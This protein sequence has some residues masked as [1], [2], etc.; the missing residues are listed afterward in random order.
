MADKSG[1]QPG[2]PTAAD[3]FAGLAKCGARNRRGEPCRRVGNGRNGRCRLHGGAS[4]GAPRGERN[5]PYKTGFY[6]ADAIAERRR[7]RALIR[8]MKRTLKDDLP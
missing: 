1:S 2:E 5:G 6:T 4:T 8:E 3:P 7:I